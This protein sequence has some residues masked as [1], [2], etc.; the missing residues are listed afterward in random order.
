MTSLRIAGLGVYL[1]EAIDNARL[2]P[3]DP[4]MSVEDMDRVGVL[5]RGIARDDETVEA[6]AAAAA[7]QALERSG[8]RADALD[9][10]IL[11]NW[12][13]RRY[14][15]DFAP[16]VQERLGARRA[17]AFDVCCACSGFV[18]GLTIADGYLHDTRL[19][20]GLVVAS[21]RSSRLVRPGSRGTLIF[22]DAAAA[23]VVDRAPGPGPR[24][25]DYLLRTDGSRNDIMDVGPDGYLRA[26]IPQKE[27]NALAAST[28]EAVA[29]SLLDRNGLSLDDIDWVVPHSGT[30]GI[31]AQLAER[32][33]LPP[34]RVLTNLP[35]VGNVT[36]ASIPSALYHFIENGTLRAGQ[37]VLSVAV[38]LGWQ[39]VAMLVTL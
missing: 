12:T 37:R 2:P 3:L 35:V 5:S 31:Q 15:P 4:P 20:A 39:A 22:G 8:L 29:R 19:R 23:A 18:Y 14:V 11:A 36:T 30:A 32:L 34:A 13:E 21:D 7:R 38:G 26:H 17:F 6:M 16:R 27:L 24:V 28:I 10:L 25:V 1:P 9:F 33:G